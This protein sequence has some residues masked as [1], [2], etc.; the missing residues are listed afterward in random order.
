M[1][2]AIHHAALLLAGIAITGSAMLHG[3]V[4]VPHLY[5]DLLE[6][7]VRRTLVSAVMLVLC[8]SIVAMFAFGGLVLSSAAA[9]LRGRQPPRAPLWIIA[10]SYVTFGV[11][12]FALVS[13]SH[14]MLGYS[15]M[16]LLVGLG[17]ALR[18]TRT[19]SPHP[20]EFRA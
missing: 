5:E 19:L 14:H 9:S 11:V 8:F 18:P 17:A 4:N 3:F 1:R 6:I 2:R 15:T 7:G 10:A 16:G 13:R 12:A 20:Q